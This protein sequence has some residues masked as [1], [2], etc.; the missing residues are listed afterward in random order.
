MI[1]LFKGEPLGGKERVK[2]SGV[3]QSKITKGTVLAGLGEERLIDILL[4]PGYRRG[5]VQEAWEVIAEN[6]K[7]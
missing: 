4:C 1:L 3:R 2:S 7:V 6:Y 5:K